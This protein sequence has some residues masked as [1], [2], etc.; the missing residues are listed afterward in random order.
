MKKETIIELTKKERLLLIKLIQIDILNKPKIFSIFKDIN[1][2][3]IENL[4]EK[5][6]YNKIQIKTPL[7]K[8]EIIDNII[9]TIIMADIEK[10]YY[11]DFVKIFKKGDKNE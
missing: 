9:K 1:K 11:K 7:E 8:K 2:K 3:E 4:I 6:N 5:L 10:E